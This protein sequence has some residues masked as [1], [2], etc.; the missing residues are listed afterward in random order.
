M[1]R[2]ER[3]RLEEEAIAAEIARQEAEAARQKAEDE[4]EE[5]HETHVY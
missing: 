1:A 5:V 4:A 3:K 2:A